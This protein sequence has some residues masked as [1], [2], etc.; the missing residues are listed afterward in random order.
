MSGE[1]RTRSCLSKL[2]RVK[3]TELLRIRLSPEEREYVETES[4]REGLT[5]STFIRRL[6][7]LRIGSGF[8]RRGTSKRSN[9]GNGSPSSSQAS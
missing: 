1:K 5:A 2:R 9:G 8:I 7:S 3:K 6:L 4:R